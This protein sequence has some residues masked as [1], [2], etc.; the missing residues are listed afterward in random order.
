MTEDLKAYFEEIADESGVDS[1]DFDD[2]DVVKR[3]LYQSK[4]KGSWH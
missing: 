2:E 1:M 4:S 3:V